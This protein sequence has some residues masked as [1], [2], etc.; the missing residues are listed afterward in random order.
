[1]WVLL[2][3]K[4]AGDLLPIRRTP[5][6]SNKS[7][8]LSVDSRGFL[9][10]RCLCS[11]LN[12]AVV[13][14]AFSFPFDKRTSLISVLEEP[15]R[16]GELADEFTCYDRLFLN[17]FEFGYRCIFVLFDNHRLIRLIRFGPRLVWLV[18]VYRSSYRIFG[19]MYEILYIYYLWN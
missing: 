3:L 6:T 9:L 19:H 14:R 16:I 15:R 10:A 13:F 11:M 12:T 8:L 1:M 2:W 7:L 4:D 5:T 18:K 17:F